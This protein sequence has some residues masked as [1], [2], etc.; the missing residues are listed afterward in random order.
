MLPSPTFSVAAFPDTGKAREAPG[1]SAFHGDQRV[2]GDVVGF[3]ALI[4][5]PTTSDVRW[6]ALGGPAPPPPPCAEPFC[7][8]L[9]PY[10]PHTVDVAAGYGAPLALQYHPR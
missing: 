10:L 8:P 5:D 2:S 4:N 7:R 3:L 1:S 9:S 6:V